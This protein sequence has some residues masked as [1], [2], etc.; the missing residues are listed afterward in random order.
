MSAP[1]TPL[2]RGR[3][4]GRVAAGEL[5][6]GTFVGLGTPTSAEVAAANGVDWVVL[7]LEHGGGSE[8][9]IGATAVATGAYGAATV[10][11]VET[12]ARIRI[13]RAL[14]AGAAGVMLPRLDSVEDIR[15]ALGHLRH[16]PHGDRGVATYN[17]AARW[18]GD[19][20]ALARSAT[21][22]L[23]V[24]Q[25]ESVQ[26]VEAAEQ[27]AALDGADVL[28]IGPLD[29]SFD[30]GVPRDLRSPEFLSA[31]DRVLAAAQRQ[32]KAAGILAADGPSACFWRDRGFRFLAVGSDSTLLAAGARAAVDQIH[33]RPVLD[34]SPTG[35]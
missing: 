13:G 26:A 2:D 14:D 4:R 6:V 23:G 10:V 15:R 5:T 16:A 27:I 9:Q 12:A 28:F 8:D 25:I 11:R 18:G 3:L 22:I 32:G 34:E 29:L 33:A 20:D 24:V 17:R 19:P 35:R 7:D 30:L 21:E 31:A 1:Q